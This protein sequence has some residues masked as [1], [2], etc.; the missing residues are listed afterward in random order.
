MLL[1]KQGS[2]ENIITGINFKY[3][4]FSAGG[5]MRH[6]QNSLMNV[7]ELMMLLGTEFKLHEGAFST[8]QINYSFDLLVQS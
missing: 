5:Y 7:T 3:K 1:E 4:N 6:E 8:M 2:M